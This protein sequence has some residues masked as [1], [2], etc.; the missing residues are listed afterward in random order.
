MDPFRVVAA[1][2]AIAGCAVAMWNIMD[3]C[4]D[5]RGDNTHVNDEHNSHVKLPFMLQ[6]R[7]DAGILRSSGKGGLPQ[8]GEEAHFVRKVPFLIA[9]TSQLVLYRTHS[10]TMDPFRAV[11]A[12]LAIA[13]CVAA[14]AQLASPAELDDCTKAAGDTGI[15]DH[16]G[17]G[18][19]DNTHANDEHNGHGENPLLLQMSVDAEILRSGGK[20]GLP[21]NEEEAHFVREGVQVKIKPHLPHGGAVG[22]VVLDTQ[23]KFFLVEG[24]EDTVYRSTDVVVHGNTIE[25]SKSRRGSGLIDPSLF[26]ALFTR[27]DD[28]QGRNS[29]RPG[30]AKLQASMASVTV[31]F[32]VCDRDDVLRSEQREFRD[33]LQLDCH[34]S[35]SLLTEKVLASMRAYV[36]HYGGHS[37]FMKLDDGTFV[38]WRRL[39]QIISEKGTTWS[40]MGA[41]MRDSLVNRD[42]SSPYY[43]PYST[44]AEDT[45]PLGMRGLGYILGGGLV[46]S[47]LELDLPTDVVLRNEDRAVSLWVMTAH[48]SGTPVDILALPC[49]TSSASSGPV[50]QEPAWESGWPMWLEV[51]PSQSGSRGQFPYVMV[52][53]L[54]KENISCLMDVFGSEDAANVDACY[55]IKVNSSATS[56]ILVSGYPRSGTTSMYEAL[57]AAVGYGFSPVDIL[58]NPELDGIRQGSAPGAAGLPKLFSLFEPCHENDDIRGDVRCPGLLSRLSKC[59]FRNVHDFFQWNDPHNFFG[60]HVLSDSFGNSSWPPPFSR[61]F[62][63]DLCD[64][65]SV[66]LFKTIAFT[67]DLARDV[68]PLLAADPDLHVIDVV[69]D[70]RGI[71]ASWKEHWQFKDTRARIGISEVCQQFLDNLAVVH[72][73]LHRVVFEELVSDPLGSLNRL[74]DALG[75]EATATVQEW[76][77]RN[78][79]ADCMHASSFSTCRTNSERM[80]SKWVDVLSETEKVTFASTPACRTISAYFN[81]A[82]PGHADAAGAPVPEAEEGKSRERIVASGTDGELL[83]ASKLAWLHVPKTGTSF[84]NVLVTWGCPGLTDADAIT[85]EPDSQRQVYVPDF[86]A[87]H[88]DRCAPGFKLVGGHTPIDGEL[89]F[90]DWPWD[91]RSARVTGRAQAFEWGLHRGHWVTMFRQPEQRILSG[92]FHGNHDVEGNNHTLREYSRMVAGCS[93]KMLNGYMC[94]HDVSITDAMV[95]TALRRLKEGFAFVGLSS[96]WDLSVCL[97][98]AMFGGTCNSR[99]FMNIRPGKHYSVKPYDTSALDGWVDPF[100]SVV[101]AYAADRFRTNLAKYDVSPAT[102]AL[103]KCVADPGGF[104]QAGQQAGLTTVQTSGGRDC[105]RCSEPKRH[106]VLPAGFEGISGLASSR[107]HPGYYYAVVDHPEVPQVVMLRDTGEVIQR[108]NLTGAELPRGRRLGKP[109]HDQMGDWESLAVAPCTLRSDVSS[110]HSEESCIYIADTG[111]NCARPSKNCSGENYRWFRDVYRILR[112][113]EPSLGDETQKSAPCD[114]FWFQFPGGQAFDVESLMMTPGGEAFVLTKEDGGHSHVF[115]LRLVDGLGEAPVVADLIGVL[116]VPELAA[117]R[118]V[119]PGIQGE[120]WVTGAS[121]RWAGLTSTGFSVRTPRHVLYFPLDGQSLG[122]QS[123]IVGIG[124]ALVSK[125]P[126]ELPSLLLKQSESVAWE[127]SNGSSYLLT[128]EGDHFIYKVD[129]DLDSQ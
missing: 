21:Q 85:D 4:G 26:V 58:R 109:G 15:M 61:S 65:S 106:G 79:N 8:N 56:T 117:G 91:R 1:Y 60:A 12:Y 28:A 33:L 54:S 112:V 86:M 126:C 88:S 105:P 3:Q 34:E 99:E 115:G 108:I 35:Y 57:A 70:P 100:D 94:G 84:A 49:S 16:C 20:G 93:V 29:M 97:F 9:K 75:L 78:F 63:Q 18:R 81:Y 37:M 72:P 111:H 74:L 13:G 27:N 119:H 89:R 116:K 5:G 22:R 55:S 47:I 14:G 36:E 23:G 122:T 45:F 24:H 110:L 71:A 80:I 43:E 82:P 11:A 64:G 98:H 48:Q 2:L 40:Y 76:I 120:A 7:V 107:R 123:L 127:L 83:N 62:L 90:G 42:E 87:T 68:L 125:Q 69:R 32:A 44:F 41:L 118:P 53:R 30:L 31:R 51:A 77:S 129:C 124:E 104:S 114:Q 6:K 73:R 92:F 10:F 52:H 17:D 102:C 95:S 38:A 46:R 19:G 59:D 128:S 96:E 121:M 66:R 39:M 67:H 103:K 113:A 50:G 101:F 25:K